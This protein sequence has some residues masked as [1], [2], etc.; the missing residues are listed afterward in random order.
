MGWGHIGVLFAWSRSE[1][2]GLCFLRLFTHWVEVVCDIDTF[3]ES[4]VDY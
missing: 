4:Y 3:D 1:R 2:T